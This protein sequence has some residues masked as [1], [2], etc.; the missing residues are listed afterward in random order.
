MIGIHLISG[1]RS[2][3]RSMTH[4]D[5]G[6]LPLVVVAKNRGIK[7]VLSENGRRAPEATFNVGYDRNSIKLSGEI[8]MQVTL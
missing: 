7:K 2:I 4:V 6:A 1:G 3:F 5:L 8:L